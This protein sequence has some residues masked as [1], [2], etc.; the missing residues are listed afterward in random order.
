MLSERIDRRIKL[1][2]HAAEQALGEREPF[3]VF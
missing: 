3:G 1:L 2:L